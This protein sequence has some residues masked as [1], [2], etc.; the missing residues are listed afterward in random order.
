MRAAVAPMTL[1][2]PVSTT[3]GDSSVPVPTS[4]REPVC[5]PS[6]EHNVGVPTGIRLTVC[7]ENRLGSVH[8]Y[9]RT[10]ATCAAKC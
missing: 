2:P 6:N 10:F 4:S 1:A 9:H 3:V 8:R 5:F 7:N